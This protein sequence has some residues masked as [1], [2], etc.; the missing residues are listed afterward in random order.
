VLAL[1]LLDRRRPAP[2]PTW[3][4]PVVA[5]LAALTGIVTTVRL[6]EVGHNGARASWGDTDMTARPGRPSGG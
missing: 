3:V 5:V 6:A 1:V 2:L 4:V